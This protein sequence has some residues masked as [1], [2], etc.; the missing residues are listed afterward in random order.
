MVAERLSIDVGPHPVSALAIDR[1]GELVAC[2]SDD[3]RVRVHSLTDG[4]EQANMLA[5]DDA[6]QSLAWDPN[7]KFLLTGGSDKSFRL[8]G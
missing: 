1:S 4:S 2:A 8:F 5:H 7:G 3:G 6:V